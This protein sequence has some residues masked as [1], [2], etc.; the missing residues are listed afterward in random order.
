MTDRYTHIE[1]FDERAVV[2]NHIPDYSAPSN[3]EKS[4][5]TGTD[6]FVLK[7]DD[8]NKPDNKTVTESSQTQADKGVTKS[9]NGFLIRRSQVRILPGVVKNAVFSIK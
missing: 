6:D 9:D 8:N 1:L 3:Q 5:A 7:I 2:E 4:I